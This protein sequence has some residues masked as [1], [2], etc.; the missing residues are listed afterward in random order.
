M[1]AQ[2]FYDQ[3][4]EEVGGFPGAEGRRE[5]LL[6]PVFFNAAKRRVGRDDMDT[7]AIAIVPIGLGQR[8]VMTNTGWCVDP[9]QDHI[10]DAEIVREGLFLNASN[11]LGQCGPIGLSVHKLALV[12]DRACQEATSAAGRIEN[13]FIKLRVQTVDDQLGDRPRRIELTRIARAL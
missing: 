1:L 13:D 5:I 10:G 7:I 9:M 11:S 3:R 6:D 2:Q 4:H 12:I 8:I